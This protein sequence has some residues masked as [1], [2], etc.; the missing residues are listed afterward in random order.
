MLKRLWNFDSELAHMN[1]ELYWTYHFLQA[2]KY[3]HAS[4]DLIG[5]H[6][7][8]SNKRALNGQKSSS[9]GGDV[10]TGVSV[11]A[12]DYRQNNCRSLAGDDY[13]SAKDASKQNNVNNVSQVA[14]FFQ[15][16]SPDNCS[17]GFAED[18]I[19]IGEF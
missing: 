2:A 3:T 13:F 7:S 16:R 12:A 4:R 18:E 14:G 15:S 5:N 10:E 1:T 9:D 6:S 11:N 17:A 8:V 19:S